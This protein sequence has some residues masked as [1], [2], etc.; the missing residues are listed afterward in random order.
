MDP[1]IYRAGELTLDAGRQEVRCGANRVHVGELTYRLLLALI[2]AAPN[3]I[4]HD[5][6]AKAVW[7]GRAVS[8]ET[9]SQRIKL[10]REAIGDDPHKPRYIEILRGRGYRLLTRPRVGPGFSPL[11]S[12]PFQRL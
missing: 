4:T 11:A 9:I 7:D 5:E 6:L 2:E 12:R 3:V 1:R 10:L 8:N